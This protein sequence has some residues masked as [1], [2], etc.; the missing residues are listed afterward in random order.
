MVRPALTRKAVGSSPTSPTNHDDVAEWLGGGLQLLPRVFDS[1]RRLQF[2]LVAQRT[3]RRSSKPGVGGSTPPESANHG[4]LAEWQCSGLL[5]R[6]T[7]KRCGGS[8]PPRSANY[9]RV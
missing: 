6:T 8:I 9:M 2:A 7:R 4:A 5:N 3:E 1:P